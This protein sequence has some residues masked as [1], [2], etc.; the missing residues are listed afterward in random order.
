ML[1]KITRFL[2]FLDDLAEVLVLHVLLSRKNWKEPRSP[3]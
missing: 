3:S 2:V 1:G